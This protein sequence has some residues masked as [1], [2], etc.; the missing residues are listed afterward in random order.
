MDHRYVTEPNENITEQRARGAAWTIRDTLA[1]GE[2]IGTISRG[3]TGWTVFSAGWGV[4]VDH[5]E[6]HRCRDT[7][8]AAVLA[9]REEAAKPGGPLA[10]DESGLTGHQRAAIDL[11]HRYAFVNPAKRDAVI[12]EAFEMSPTQ[13]MSEWNALLNDPRALAYEPTV[14]NRHRRIRDMRKASRSRTPVPA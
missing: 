1:D 12:W 9:A 6:V 2:K 11:M 7:A 5:N 3:E 4:K 8:L 14:I 10:V 13:F